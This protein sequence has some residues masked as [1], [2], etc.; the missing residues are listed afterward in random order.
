MVKYPF[1]NGKI[2]ASKQKVGS[3]KTETV[4]IIEWGRF[5]TANFPFQNGQLFVLKRPNDKFKTANF[6]YQNGQTAFRNAKK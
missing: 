2:S 4:Y 6:L 3:Y 5:K 1:L